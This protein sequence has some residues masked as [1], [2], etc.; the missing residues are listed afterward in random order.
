MR[1]RLIGLLVAAIVAGCSPADPAVSN[2]P[3]AAGPASSESAASSAAVATPSAEPT[4]VP[5]PS[6]APARWTDCGG[7]FSCT[8][9]RVPRD[10]DA[11]S[12]GYL[13]I[14][15][16]RLAAAEPAERIGTLFLNPGGPGM[17][18]VE[19][20]RD[21]KGYF[22][23]E[24]HERFDIVG[25]DP[26][27]VNTSTAIRCI[28]NLDGHDALDMSPDSAA[29]LDAL[30][31]AAEE[32]ADACA[33]RNATLLPHL[34]TDDVV[35]DLDLLRIAVGDDRLTY[36]GFS[37]GTLIGAL[38]A[39]RFP[40]R[41]RALAL[42]GAVDPSQDLR[43][44]R[45]DQAVAF[46]GALTRFLADC[47]GRASCPFHEGGRS[48][49]AFDAL[50]ADL[51][52]EPIPSISLPDRRVVG[53]GLAWSAVLAGLYS[54]SYWPI[55]ASALAL[56]KEG[57][58]ALLLAISDPFR[59]RKPNGAYSNL[60]DAYVANICL[61]YPAPT[62]A[63]D[64]AG[65]AAEFENEAPHFAP[66]VAYNDLICAFWGVPA[67]GDPH[68]VS[69]PEAPPILVVGTTGDPATPYAWAE[70]LASQLESAVLVTREGE[71]HTG[72][73]DSVC[74]QRAVNAYLVSLE[75]PED[76]LRCS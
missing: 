27:G 57:D 61:D 32:Y 35:S 62:D 37:Y 14:S 72:Y 43:S 56:A 63:G 3:S 70:A 51:D 55:L 46:E 49:Q 39:E 23:D 67:T 53:P 6:V 66:L 58:G 26:R 54:E 36:L 10:H 2:G 30:V 1:R 45:A 19:F 64:Y 47:A 16:I 44:F 29:E 13:N 73:L 71:G 17:S 60:Q 31:A 33:Q 5:E 76:G 74:V 21:G 69:A 38:Y 65:W 59:G 42:D 68:P 24:L 75:V 25:F 52:R 28:D 41:V 9:V 50:M 15:L 8:E 4:P 11:P 48:A 18:G 34:S 7:G 40:D 20:V 22:P 12:D